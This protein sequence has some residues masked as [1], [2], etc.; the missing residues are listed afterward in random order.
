MS[1][2]SLNVTRRAAV[3]GVAGLV[4]VIALFL[5]W[6]SVTVS[7]SF[8]GVSH[9]ITGTV[10][11]WRVLTDM[12]WLLLLLGIATMAGA[13]VL[14]SGR[15]TVREIL[16]QR[17]L[18]AVGGA[19]TVGAVHRLASIPAKGG[20]PPGIHLGREV[21]AFLAVAASLGILGGAASMLAAGRRPGEAGTSANLRV[22]SSRR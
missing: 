20:V 16:V 14:V 18:V 7:A 4:L 21:G 6:Y 19:G 13:G 5:P 17:A 1:L 9:S 3:T 2:S 11:G 22:A 15:L 8:A 12:R 10:T